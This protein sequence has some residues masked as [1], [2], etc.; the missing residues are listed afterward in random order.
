MRARRQHQAA[1][2]IKVWLQ[3]VPGSA[4]DKD[5]E[6]FLTI[7]LRNYGIP[8]RLLHVLRGGDVSVLGRRVLTQENIFATAA[9]RIQRDD[10]AKVTNLIAAASFSQDGSNGRVVIQIPPS[11]QPPP[12]LSFRT[13]QEHNPFA[14]TL[15]RA[16]EYSRFMKFLNS[17]GSAVDFVPLESKLP[18]P[19]HL[20]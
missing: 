2:G 14:G 11:L 18:K 5:I 6:T 8:V 4:N 7:S 17:G 10:M 20:Y 16:S 9:V 13:E 1:T 19:T 15:E 12:A 3:G